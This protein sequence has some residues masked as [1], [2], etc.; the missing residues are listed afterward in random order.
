M[1]VRNDE[2]ELPK[3]IVERRAR[4]R[5]VVRMATS[6]TISESVFVR[7]EPEVVWDFTQD[8]ARR[9]RWD[10]SVREAEVL[11]EAPRRR[12]RVKGVG[13]FSCVLEYK[14]FERPR[15]ASLAMTEVESSRWIVGGGGAWSYERSGHGTVWTQTN[16]LRLGLGPL[17]W[18]AGPLVG[19]Q[20]RRATSKAMLRAA[21]AIDKQV[22]LGARWSWTWTRWGAVAA[23]WALVMSALGLFM[24]GRNSP[25]GRIIFLPASPTWFC[26]DE[27]GVDVG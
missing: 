12:V 16:T 24:Q 23:L 9:A 18:L 5:R 26:L 21:R 25:G 17:G 8:F 13:G 27:C 7:A 20:L 14:Q 6:V 4:L 11:G 1:F 22:R 2:A 15:R 3:R 19:W 10:E